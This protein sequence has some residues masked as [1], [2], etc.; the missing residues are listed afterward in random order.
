MA[1]PRNIRESI[2]KFE[3]GC[4]TR[5]LAEC[6][7]TINQVKAHRRQTIHNLEQAHLHER[8]EKLRRKVGRI[9]GTRKSTDK[10]IER[11]WLEA[12]KQT[13]N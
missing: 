5:E 10:E 7:R 13:S 8:M 2:L 12:G 11:L 1:V 9:I 6:V 3:C 4:S